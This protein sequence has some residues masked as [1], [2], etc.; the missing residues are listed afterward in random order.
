VQKILEEGTEF[1]WL[2]RVADFW[3]EVV[4]AVVIRA[5]DLHRRSCCMELVNYTSL[6][7]F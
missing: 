3:L 2:V 5:R 6:F 7:I 4:C 1:L